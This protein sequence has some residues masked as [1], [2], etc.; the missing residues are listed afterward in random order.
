MTLGADSVSRLSPT[1]V[2]LTKPCSGFTD[3]SIFAGASGRQSSRVGRLP[4]QMGFA[5]R[6]M[7]GDP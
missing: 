2:Y 5:V 1:A 7:P 6:T 3:F 4:P